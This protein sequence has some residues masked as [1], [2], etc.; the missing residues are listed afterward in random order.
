M[1]TGPRRFKRLRWV[2]ITLVGAAALLLV[3]VG[4]I[5]L[6]STGRAIDITILDVASSVSATRNADT[7]RI[8]AYNIAHGRGLAESN[9][10]GGGA[11]K[12]AERLQAIA[13]LLRDQSLDIVVLNEVDFDSAWSGGVNQARF[14][15]E[16]ADF[17]HI[18]EQANIDTGLPFFRLRYGNALLSRF[19]ITGAELIEF[20]AFRRSEAL[21]AGSKQGLVCEVQLGDGRSVR[22][23]AVHLEH[24]DEA[25]RV[26]SAQIIIDLAQQAGPPL[27]AAG[28]FNSTPLG[29][30]QAQQ[31]AAGRNALTKLLDSGIFS[32]NR[33]DAPVGVDDL[34][35]ASDQPR[36]II[37]WVLVPSD[38]ALQSY[39]V[40]AVSHSDH[41]PVIVEL[42]PI[43]R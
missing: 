23:I 31:D 32:T 28:D 11:E 29:F 42:S 36:T 18:V 12:R 22:I 41:R 17:S 33:F 7:L 24:R 15:A 16:H 39:E 30:P 34:T 5:R 14:I 35:F 38:F 25:T 6:T 40:L 21:I 1:K 26:E 43:P 20:P 37:D 9:W 8:G 10:G 4:A 19:P 2:V 13:T 27:I 3:W